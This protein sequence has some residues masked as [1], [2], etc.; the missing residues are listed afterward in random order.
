MSMGEGAGLGM[1]GAHRGGEVM[2]WTDR[3]LHRDR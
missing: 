3:V 1:G 2:D